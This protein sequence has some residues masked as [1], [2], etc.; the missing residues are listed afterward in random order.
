M[1]NKPV[2]T[3]KDKKSFEKIFNGIF[4]KFQPFIKNGKLVTGV[5]FVS[6]S[7]E[8]VIFEIEDYEF[9]TSNKGITNKK[10]A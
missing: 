3:V 1:K 2:K 5:K 7:D 9:R 4:N 10:R 6:Y 8:K